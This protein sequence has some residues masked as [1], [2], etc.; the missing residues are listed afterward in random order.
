MRL[1]NKVAAIT[2]GNSGVG[3]ATARGFASQGAKLAILGRNS[4]TLDQAATTLG[5]AL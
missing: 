3:L 2:G 5:R 1:A 4:A